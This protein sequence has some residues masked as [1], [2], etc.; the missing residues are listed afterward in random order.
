VPSVAAR[1]F[2]KVAM[3]CRQEMIAS[4][5]AVRSSSLRPAMARVAAA[6]SVVGE[7]STVAMPAKD[8]MPRLIPGVRSLT[9]WVAACCAAASR[10]GLTSVASIDSET[11]MASITVALFRGCLASAVGPAIATVSSTRPTRITAVG[12]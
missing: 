6:R 3:V 7:T 8:T 1:V 4:P 11:S 2:E 10:F 5:V 12:R 9:N